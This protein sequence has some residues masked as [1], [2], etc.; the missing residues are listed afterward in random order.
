MLPSFIMERSWR[1]IKY[2][3]E[4]LHLLKIKNF[5]SLKD[6]VKKNEEVRHT[7]GENIFKIHMW[8]KKNFA[9]RI[10][11]EHLQLSNNK[12]NSSI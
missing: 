10:H 6:T 8:R 9:A 4:T 7:L 12:I 2:H 5:Y 11:K 1:N 3:V